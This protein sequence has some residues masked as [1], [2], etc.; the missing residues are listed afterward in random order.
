MSSTAMHRCRKCNW[1]EPRCLCVE[2]VQ[3]PKMVQVS[4]QEL[5]TLRA[6]AK[7]Y[8]EGRDVWSVVTKDGISVNIGVQRQCIK[9]AKEYNESPAFQNGYTCRKVRVCKEVAS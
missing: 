3:Q 8:D 5:A 1:P 6:K 7:A 9:L 4:E 2:P